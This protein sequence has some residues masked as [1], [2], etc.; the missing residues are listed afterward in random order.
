[1]TIH[2][3]STTSQ[4]RACG[5]CAAGAMGHLRN[6]GCILLA[7]LVAVAAAA[8]DVDSVVQAASTGP[9]SAQ[10]AEELWKIDVG[11]KMA[12]QAPHDALR[13]G[14][15]HLEL[16]T[17]LES[18]AKKAA[19]GALAAR[20]A[21]AASQLESDALSFG[22]NQKLA[23][24]PAAAGCHCGKQGGWGVVDAARKI[25]LGEERD[26]PGADP[27][28]TGK[29]TRPSALTAADNCPCRSSVVSAVT[30]VLEEKLSS[31]TREL[32]SRTSAALALRR[33]LV[34]M[35]LPREL[36]AGLTDDLNRELRQTYEEGSDLG[37]TIGGAVPSEDGS[38][39]AGGDGGGRVPV[40]VV[41]NQAPYFYGEPGEYVT[42]GQAPFVRASEERQG[43]GVKVVLNIE[44]QIMLPTPIPAVG[45][46]GLYA[47]APALPF[48]PHYLKAGRKTETLR[49][50][51]A[52]TTPARHPRR[53]AIRHSALPAGDSALVSRRK[54]RAHTG[55][56]ERHAQDR[57]TVQRA[58]AK[59][60]HFHAVPHMDQVTRR[61]AIRTAPG[62]AE[63][64][65]SVGS[66]AAVP[67]TARARTERVKAKVQA[68]RRAAAP[69][70]ASKVAGDITAAVQNLAAAE[71]K[72]RK[73]SASLARGKDAK[74]EGAQGLAGK[75]LSALSP[76]KGSPAPDASGE[77]KRWEMA[78]ERLIQTAKA[79]QEVAQSR[80]AEMRTQLEHPQGH[81]QAKARL[82]A[83]H[84][85]A[86][87]GAEGARGGFLGGYKGPFI[88][89]KE[90]PKDMRSEMVARLQPQ[91]RAVLKERKAAWEK[92]YGPLAIA[93]KLMHPADADPT[94]FTGKLREQPR[95]VKRVAHLD[96]KSAAR[97]R[98]ELDRAFE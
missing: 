33:A 25:V 79:L 12:L 46:G 18:E 81:A 72:G 36:A 32:G 1:M 96:S 2:K 67:Q 60:D 68:L 15:K 4:C 52:Q 87:S 78:R 6:A 49:A 82:V 86:L 42:G 71:A 48:A 11:G 92:R 16:M 88:G 90:A 83:L 65:G 37:E 23:A 62:S 66:P 64:Q 56:T 57:A 93:H 14:P 30:S 73:A 59:T 8:P 38:G 43:K 85:I 58:E 31:L 5:L 44:N 45:C 55:A 94:E 41:V 39:D 84:Q 40:E 19:G 54:G 97:A 53:P 7:L 21:K 51:A 77:K 17:G 76:W 3:S 9:V 26:A 70:D 98:R 20:N 91:M 75:L 22:M 61:T 69:A 13:K 35:R 24:L 28:T 80:A 10:E 34:S 95:I 50:A 29:S 63:S 89:D 74:S 47:C 27:V